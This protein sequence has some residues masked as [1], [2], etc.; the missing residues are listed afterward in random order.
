MIIQY[1]FDAVKQY[2]IT[3]ALTL[4]ETKAKHTTRPQQLQNLI[5]K[6]YEQR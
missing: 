6:S 1:N 5:E 2:I 3:V 4:I